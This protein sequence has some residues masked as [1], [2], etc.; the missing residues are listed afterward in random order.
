[1]LVNSQFCQHSCCW[2]VS[3][4][5]PPVP[6]QLRHDGHLP[7]CIC[8][9]VHTQWV[10]SF[11]FSF[12]SLLISNQLKEIFFSVYKTL[13]DPELLLQEEQELRKWP[14]P[15]TTSLSSKGTQWRSSA[16][17]HILGVLCS[18]GMSNTPNKASSY[19]WNT[20]QEE[21]SKVSRPVLTNVRHLSIWR[22]HQLKRKT[23]PCITVFWV[24][25]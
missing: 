13:P 7:L 19:S 6:L 1:M 22:N 11:L 9:N 16:T 20:S 21:V 12:S 2:I 15:R 4:K 18:S 25:Q 5:E 14:S 17:T 3:R 10:H 23:Q 8:D 24:T